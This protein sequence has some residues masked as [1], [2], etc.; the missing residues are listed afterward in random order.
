VLAAAL[1]CVPSVAWAG[2]TGSGT[3]V[4][5]VAGGLDGPRQVRDY[6]GHRLVVA[7][8][9]S[10]EISAV[11][12]RSGTVTTLLTGLYSPQGVGYDDGLLFVALGGP[13]P[14][15]EA[16]GCRR[17]PGR[18]SRRWWSPGRTARS[19]GPSTCRPTSW[20]TTPD[21][22]LQRRPDGSL[23]DSLSNP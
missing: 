9:D 10:G 23:P 15:N 5:R 16:G 7:E 3:A 18:R 4:T 12:P 14:P 8:S 21:G 22:Q 2:G 1:L 13:P 17:H 6:P 19:C 20:P 11:D